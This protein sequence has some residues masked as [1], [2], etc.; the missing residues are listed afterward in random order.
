MTSFARYDCQ[1][2]HG[3][4]TPVDHRFSYRSPMWLLDVDR[5]PS[6]PA[7]IGFLGRFDTADHWPAGTRSIR[8]GV[9]EFL[10][11][12]GISAPAQVLML[13][14]ARSFGHC[15][16]PL[17][18]YWCYDE[19]G[20][21]RNII[22][23]VH[24]T[25]HGRHAYLLS[26]DEA[27]RDA[28]DKQ[29][30]VSPFFSADGRYR[31]RITAPV[32]RL[33]VVIALERDGGVPF[34]ATMHGDRQP[35]TR[36]ALLTRPLAQLRVSALIK[37]QGIKLWRRGVQVQPRTGTPAIEAALAGNLQART[38]GGKPAGKPAGRS[39]ARTDG[40]SV[41]AHPDSPAASP[42]QSRAKEASC[43]VVH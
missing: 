17:S 3:R 23:E 41:P 32:D 22:A 6:L 28:V 15:F 4:K 21:Q 2:S 33:T 43:P 1:I 5:V 30:Y 40:K 26:P 25:Y 12:Q 34:T 9:D 14:G 11:T 42:V 35:A 16:N 29:F 18:V 13:T 7:P 8:A 24:N 10:A 19:S 27:G 37:W 31:M 20:R 36:W 38:H 39:D